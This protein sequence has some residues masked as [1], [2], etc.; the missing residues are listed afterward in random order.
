M[1]Q[2][3]KQRLRTIADL[4]GRTVAAR[5][6]RDLVSAL[7]ADLGGDVSAAQAELVQR[8]G[9]LGAYLEDAEARWLAGDNVDVTAWLSAIDRQRRTL[10]ALDLE[11]RARPVPSLD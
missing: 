8:A 5:R 1:V 11:R 7:T 2:P 3:S 9:L 6:A 10:M 4:D